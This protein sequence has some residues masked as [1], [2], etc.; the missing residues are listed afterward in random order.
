MSPLRL[1]S[2]AG[3]ATA[4][5]FT[6]W[7]AVNSKDWGFALCISKLF[8]SMIKKREEKKRKP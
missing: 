3:L 1:K 6:A 2:N 7:S 5:A 4:G 8:V